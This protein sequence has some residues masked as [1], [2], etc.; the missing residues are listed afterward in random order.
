MIVVV[1]LVVP[2]VLVIVEALV[3]LREYGECAVYGLFMQLSQSFRFNAGP[4]AIE[5]DVTNEVD[6]LGL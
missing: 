3:G 2:V 4:D 5:T 1:I 6:A